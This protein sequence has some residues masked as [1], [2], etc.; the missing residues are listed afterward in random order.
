AAVGQLLLKLTTPGVPDVYQGDELWRLSMVD[1]D[2][3]RPVDFDARRTALA[4]LDSGAPIDRTTI[5]LHIIRRAL[6]LRASRPEPFAGAYNPLP[7]DDRL[8][9]FTRGAHEILAV[10][11]LREDVTDATF[12]LPADATGEW[13]NVLAGSGAAVGDAPPLTLGERV[14]FDDVRFGDWPVALLERV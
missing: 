10:I 1:P 12:T 8:C 4:A 6:A 3:R 14:A 2:N 13:R 11:A 7:A 5:K 9:A